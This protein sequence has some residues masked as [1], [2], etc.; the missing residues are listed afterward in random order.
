MK[1]AGEMEGCHNYRKNEK[2]IDHKQMF[3]TQKNLHSGSVNENILRNDTHI[4]KK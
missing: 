4:Y 2:S 1:C 3:D